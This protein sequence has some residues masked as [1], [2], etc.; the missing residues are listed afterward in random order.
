MF[1]CQTPHAERTEVFIGGKIVNP[2]SNQLLVYKGNKLLDTIILE[3]DNRFSYYLN[4]GEIPGDYKLTHY[5]ESQT[6]YLHPGD[7]IL[8][9]ANTM[10]FDESLY[11][12]G[13][14]AHKN[15]LLID[16]YLLNEKTSQILLAS[17]Q[18]TPPEFK[19]LADSIYQQRKELLDQR[20]T[21]HEFPP[22]FIDYAK[23]VIQYQ[24]YHLRE[25]YLYLINRYYPHQVARLN[26]EFFAYREQVDFNDPV[27]QTNPAYVRFIEIYLLNESLR[28]T[29]SGEGEMPNINAPENIKL[30]IDLIDSLSQL[31]PV[32]DQIFFNLGSFGMVMG[33]SREDMVD[34][35]T[36][37]IRKGYGRQERDVLRQLGY[38][39]LAFLPGVNIGIVPAVTPSGEQIGLDDVINRKTVLFLWS[40][41][42]LE[43][44]REVHALM[45]SYRNQFPELDFIGI[46]IDVG[47]VQRWKATMREEG[48]DPQY[49]YQLG[50]LGEIQELH[51]LRNYLTKS[52]FLNADGMVI[53]GDADYNSREYEE[54][55]RELVEFPETL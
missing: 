24:S 36:Q 13:V 7:S 2:Y 30:R 50:R 19:H 43:H 35:L 49:E 34:I 14:G 11:F 3:P 41:Y 4:I 45:D 1:G 48:L 51:L 40:S 54:H 21:K 16:L 47:E 26:D 25:R 39:Q 53:L 44:T 17:G 32:R 20:V 29:P 38:I 9:Y 12:S 42:A 15:N 23:G 22:E 55:L 37:L 33:S 28:L 6:L 27:L 46:N 8:M 10:E 31:Q 18:I 5:N 52:V